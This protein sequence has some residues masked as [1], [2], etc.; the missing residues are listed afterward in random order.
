MD[1]DLNPEQSRIEPNGKYLNAKETAV[2]LRTSVGSVR[3]MAW[4]GQL[5][6]YKLKRR[7]IFKRAD[8]DRLIEA[9]RKGGFR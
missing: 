8:L 1:R 4:R 5:P 7:L 6:Y 9:S 3:N 2:Y